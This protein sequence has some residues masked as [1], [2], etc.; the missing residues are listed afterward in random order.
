MTGYNRLCYMIMTCQTNNCMQDF[1][2]SHLGVD[3]LGVDI[4]GVDGLGLV[5]ISGR[6]PVNR[7]KDGEGGRVCIV[8]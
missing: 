4:S 7:R 1:T 8:V 5:D 3:I 2:S 6:T